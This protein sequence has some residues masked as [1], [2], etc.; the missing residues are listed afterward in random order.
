[1]SGYG[2]MRAE[3]FRWFLIKK[4]G[5]NAKAIIISITDVAVKSLQQAV[6]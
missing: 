4:I 6:S 2:Y 1:M 5:K 3:S